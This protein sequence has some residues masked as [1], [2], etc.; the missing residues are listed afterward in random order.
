MGTLLLDNTCTTLVS[1]C[2]HSCLKVS[3]FYF[4]LVCIK[5]FKFW[6]RRFV[7]GKHVLWYQL[8]P[9]EN[10]QTRRKFSP[11]VSFSPFWRVHQ[12]LWEK[13]RW[14]KKLH[15]LHCP[16]D[17]PQEEFKR[18][19]QDCAGVNFMER[20]EFF[21]LLSF[22]YLALKIFNRLPNVGLKEAIMFWVFLFPSMNYYVQPNEFT[23]CE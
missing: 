4:Y 19:S 12:T 7:Y 22:P 1:Q 10:S 21:L 2:I 6:K 3:F 11:A 20:E 17:F 13:Q 15:Y 14:Q 9:F 16:S 18:S 8:N 23:I 5:I